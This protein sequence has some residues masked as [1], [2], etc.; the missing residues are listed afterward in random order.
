V[1]LDL[2]REALEV[3]AGVVFALAA[4]QVERPAVP[5]AGQDAA[6]DFAFMQRAGGMRADALGGDEFAVDQKY[7]DRLI[8]DRNAQGLAATQGLG[9][10]DPV[11]DH[12]AARK[13]AASGECGELCGR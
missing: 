3:Q 11:V 13:S 6:V 2:H 7:R 8:A 4:V 5:G 9:P 12:A 10:A 1:T